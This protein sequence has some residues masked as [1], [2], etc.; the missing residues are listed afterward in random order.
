MTCTDHTESV[1]D[2][3]DDSKGCGPHYFSTHRF[4]AILITSC[5]SY[6]DA[7][8]ED[9]ARTYVKGHFHFTW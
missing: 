3:T 9:R 6:G 7:E 5:Q 8:C 4:G 1:S 2:V